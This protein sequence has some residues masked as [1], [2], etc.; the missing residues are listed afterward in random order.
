[1]SGHLTVNDD[2]RKQGVLSCYQHNIKTKDFLFDAEQEP[3]IQALQNLYEKLVASEHKTIPYGLDRFLSFVGNTFEQNKAQPDIQGLYIW[4]GVGRGKTYLMNLFYQCLPIDKKLRLHFHRFMQIAHE[5]LNTLEGVEDPLQQ[6]AKNF[7]SKAQIICLDEVHVIDITDAMLLGRLLDHLF[8]LNIVL[9]STSNFAP[10]ELYKDGLQRKQF[11][12]AVSLLEKHTQVIELKGSKDYRLQMMQQSTLYQ[13]ASGELS[14][15][16][17]E[18]QFEALAGIQLHRERRE[19]IINQRSIP[20]KRWSDGIAWFSFDALCT[21]FRSTADYLQIGRYFH[22]VFISD[23]PIMATDQD[24]K[25]R[26]FINMI[27]TFY[28]L[29][30]NIVVS[31]AALPEELYTSERLAFEFKR[32]AS[33]LR[34]MQSK[35][36]LAEKHI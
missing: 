8:S 20:V 22:T 3:V 33:R 30:V 25:A 27:D 36:Y 9:V 4:G 26:R 18:Q 7:A 23:I 31:A 13:I 29:H 15:Q 28:D 17:L 24:D 34:E 14:E 32:T 6:V 1:M 21:D 19:V 5:E 16:R 12:S 2:E 11:L 35:D 10:H